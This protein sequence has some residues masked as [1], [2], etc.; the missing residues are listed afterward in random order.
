MKIYW[1]TIN[2]LKKSKLVLE[3]QRKLVHFVKIIVTFGGILKK[4]EEFPRKNEKFYE[5][6]F[7]AC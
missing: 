6:R 2:L 3:N 1:K 5:Q 7:L 4:I